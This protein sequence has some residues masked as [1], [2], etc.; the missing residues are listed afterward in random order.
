MHSFDSRQSFK[1]E[2][3][4]KTSNFKNEHLINAPITV[5]TS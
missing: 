3:I 4:S 1:P 5:L 2:E